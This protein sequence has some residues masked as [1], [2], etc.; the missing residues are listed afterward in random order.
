MRYW[1]VFLGIMWHNLLTFKRYV[2]NTLSSL[3]TLYLV[4]VLL[5][6]GARSVGG[7][8]F[9]LS[10]TQDGLI[11]GYFIWSLAI[12]TFSELSWGLT[13]EAQ[14]GTLEQLY[15]SPVGF[16]F[17]AAARSVSNLMLTLVANFL[18][19]LLAMATAGRW[20]SVDLVSLI[21]ILLLTIIGVIGLSFAI[22][23][24]ALIHKRIQAFL[25]LMQFVLVGFIAIPW[26]QFPWARYLPLAMGNH[27]SR[28][29]MAE[30]LRLW[31]LNPGDLLVLGA[32]A[33]GYLVLG[34]FAFGWAERVARDR[35]LLGQY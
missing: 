35:G 27:L 26:A 23:G 8:G 25:Q 5:F 10:G 30:G 28:Q 13:N 24:L 14:Q 21:P 33:V 31:Q 18:I 3:V 20:L 32:T 9:A 7:P 1:Y 4:F 15:L 2:F 11:I 22:G 6:F 17:V 34:V 19:L 29:V 12:F 16:R